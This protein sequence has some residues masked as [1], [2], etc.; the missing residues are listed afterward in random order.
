LISDFESTAEV[1]SGIRT[2]QQEYPFKDAIELKII[3]NDSTYISIHL[4]VEYALEYVSEKVDGALSFRVKSMN[5]YFIPITGTNV[6]ENCK[7]TTELNY[8]KDFKVCGI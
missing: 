8:T 3:N 4:T 1:I 6:E 7:L 2:I 5:E